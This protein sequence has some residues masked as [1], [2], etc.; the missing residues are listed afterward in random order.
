MTTFAD[1][2]MLL[3]CFFVLLFSFSQTSQKKFSTVSQSFSKAFGIPNQTLPFQLETGSSIIELES[4]EQLIGT[5][6]F[7]E[8][9]SLEEAGIAHEQLPSQALAGLSQQLAQAFYQGESGSGLNFELD[10]NVLTIQID[11]A[12]AYASGSGF[13]QPKAEHYLD[14]ISSILRDFPGSIEVVGHTDNQAVQNDLYTNNVDLSL[15]RAKA[16]AVVLAKHL[17]NRTISISGKGDS[18]P[19]ASNNTFQGRE[20]NRRV[21]IIV[22]HGSQQ[23]TPLNLYKEE[24]VN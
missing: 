7:N 8:A 19:V 5:R 24:T 4:G 16:V 13:L 10:S 6:R 3:L 17:P 11:S 9:G 22:T 20:Q 14:K 21:E 23:I 18:Q 15:A 12:I 2:M 1:M